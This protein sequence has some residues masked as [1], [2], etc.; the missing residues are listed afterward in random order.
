[1]KLLIFFLL[2]LVIIIGCESYK[3]HSYLGEIPHIANKFYIEIDKLQQ[4]LTKTT[5]AEKGTKILNQIAALK[6]EADE[7]LRNYFRSFELP[8][9]IPFS[10]EI[11]E[12]VFKIQ[13]IEVVQIRFNEVEFKAFLTASVDSKNPVFTYLRFTDE[14]GRKLPGWILLLS[15]F[16][17]T[18]DQGYATTG[19]YKGIHHLHNA[20]RLV[21]KSAQDF[22]NNLTINH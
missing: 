4:N 13:S 5:D 18:K 21:V 15:P 17:L 10:Q 1:M 2:S 20:D 16:N 22:E 19:T 14:H 11:N 12:D 8:L 6:K 3:K 7:E 9:T